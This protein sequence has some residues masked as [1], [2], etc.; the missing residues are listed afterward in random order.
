MLIQNQTACTAVKLYIL[1]SHMTLFN[2]LIF[3]IYRLSVGKAT[4]HEVHK[5]L[6]LT[7]VLL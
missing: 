7:S 1:Q 2:I 3:M 5:A 6:A 4:S